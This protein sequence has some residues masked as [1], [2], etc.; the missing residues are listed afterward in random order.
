MS[1]SGFADDAQLFVAAGR[2]SHR[3]RSVMPTRYD[4]LKSEPVIAVALGFTAT[5]AGVLGLL[6][7]AAQALP[8]F[9]RWIQRLIGN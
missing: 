3:Q 9:G 4:W 2:R 7:S 6:L 1:G 8:S 5:F